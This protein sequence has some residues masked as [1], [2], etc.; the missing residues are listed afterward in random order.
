[1]L[2]GKQKTDMLCVLEGVWCTELRI[3]LVAFLFWWEKTDVLCVLEGFWCTD[4]RIVLIAFFA[5]V[6]G[7]CTENMLYYLHY[8]Y[9]VWRE[10]DAFF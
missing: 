3:V 5:L 10:S 7:N 2:L 1:M 8:L 4:L 6:G 9:F